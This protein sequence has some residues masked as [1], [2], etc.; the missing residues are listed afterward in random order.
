MP[1]TIENIKFLTVIEAAN[2]LSVSHLT[3]R[4]WIKKGKLESVR[5]GRPL[6]IRYDDIMKLLKG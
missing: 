5:I 1:K 3:I 2:L 6:Y 4:N